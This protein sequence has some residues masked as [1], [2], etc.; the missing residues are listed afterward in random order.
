MM[1]A[2]RETFTMDS[3]EETELEDAVKKG[4][5]VLPQGTTVNEMFLYTGGSVRLFLKPLKPVKTVV[6]ELLTKKNHQAPDMGK[7]IG[8]GGVGDS[9]AGAVKKY[10]SQA[11]SMKFTITK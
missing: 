7:L 11:V 3:W 9:S 4:A 6:S 5:L 2:D 10:P 8:A 1:S